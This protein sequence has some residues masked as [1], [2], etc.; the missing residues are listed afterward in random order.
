METSASF[1]ARSAPLLYPTNLLVR[2]WRGVGKGN[3]PTYST[4]VRFEVK[5]GDDP[6][7]TYLIVTVDIE[8]PDEIVDIYAEKLL[9]LQVDEGLPFYI[10]PVRPL[11]ETKVG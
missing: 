1:E 11:P 5:P 8:D 4:V 9:G 10:V 3:L 7:G 6:A 2:L